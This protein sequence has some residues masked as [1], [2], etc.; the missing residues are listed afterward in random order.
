[1]ARK[2]RTQAD[3]DERIIRQIDSLVGKRKRSQFLERAAIAQLRLE[4]LK[5]WGRFR[6]RL[7]GRGV[8]LEDYYAAREELEGRGG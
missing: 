7:K 8:T 6:E 1:M 4:A 2:R 3:M 5:A